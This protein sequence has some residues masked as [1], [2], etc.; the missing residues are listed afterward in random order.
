MR[1][2]EHSNFTGVMP[3]TESSSQQVETFSGKLHCQVST[4]FNLITNHIDIL[5][6]DVDVPIAPAPCLEQLDL[7][8]F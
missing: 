1:L 4:F 8:Q 6:N 7:A 3:G 5:L 2:N